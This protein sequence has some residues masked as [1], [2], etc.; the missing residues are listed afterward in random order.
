M[1][2]PGR[3]KVAIIAWRLAQHRLQEHQSLVLFAI[4]TTGGWGVLEPLDAIAEIGF[5]PAADRMFMASDGLGN[6]G[7]TLTAIR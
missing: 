4:R 6:D 5:E 7:H 1:G 3:F 2:A